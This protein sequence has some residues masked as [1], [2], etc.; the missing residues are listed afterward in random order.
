MVLGE[1]A[2]VD[3]AARQRMYAIPPRRSVASTSGSKRPT[4]LPEPIEEYGAITPP[5]A[6][7]VSDCGVAPAAHTR[8][9]MIPDYLR[10]S[11]WTRHRVL[12]AACAAV[13]LVAV[14]ALLTSGLT[15]W[16]GGERQLAVDTTDEIVG[17]ASVAGTSSDGTS[18]DP[19]AIH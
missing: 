3:P 17:G 1:P 12:L 4:R 5:P 14:T 13:L 15:G 10:A 18:C 2:E 19:V 11:T 9:D 6:T 16:L 7:C 8:P